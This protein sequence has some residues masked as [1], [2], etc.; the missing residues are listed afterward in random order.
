MCLAELALIHLYPNELSQELYYYPFAVNL[1]SCN[2]NCNTF[3]DRSSRVCVPYKTE[4][5]NLNIL[6]VNA[7]INE[8]K[9]L[10]KHISCKCECKFHSKTCNSIKSGIMINVLVSVKVRNNIAYIKKVIFRILLHLVAKMVD[11]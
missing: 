11:M 5:L 7:G 3:D 4:D 8:L 9:K 1:N 2:G 6:K 10:M